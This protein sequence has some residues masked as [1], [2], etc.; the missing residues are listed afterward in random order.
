MREIEVRIWTPF[1][2]DNEPLMA[3]LD[4]HP[5]LMSDGCQEYLAYTKAKTSGKIIDQLRDMIGFCET[6]NLQRRRSTLV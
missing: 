2:Q 4:F 3:L 1:N 6:T 5:E